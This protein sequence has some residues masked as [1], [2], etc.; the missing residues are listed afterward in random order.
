MASPRNPRHHERRTRRPAKQETRDSPRAQRLA[1][2]SGAGPTEGAG[3]PAGRA[4][5]DAV[6]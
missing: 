6:V 1:A 2:A 4:F 5:G 3:S